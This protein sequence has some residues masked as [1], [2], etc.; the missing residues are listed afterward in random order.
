MTKKSLVPTI[1]SIWATPG[2]RRFQNEFGS[3][4]TELLKDFGNI[5]EI[6]AFNELQ[7]DTSFPKI[8]VSET[9]LGYGVDIAVAGFA[10]D[11]VNLEL[12]D[13]ILIISAEKK[14]E[15]EEEDKNY[16]RKEISSRSFKRVVRFPKKIDTS[17]AIANYDK[18]IIQLSINKFVEEIK[19]ES[20]KININ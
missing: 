15:N 1:G 20:I 10:K 17:T 5:G 2:L 6:S 14:E 16:I 11:D 12:K 19:D 9:D 13:N 7:S 18:G 3:I 4:F 8:N